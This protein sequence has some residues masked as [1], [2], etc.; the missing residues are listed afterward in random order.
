MQLQFDALTIAN[1]EELHETLLAYSLS[2]ESLLELD[3]HNVNK[4][5]LSAIQLFL[6]LQKTLH[7]EKRQLKLT[8]CTNGVMAALALCGCEKILAGDCQ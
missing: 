7:N 3:L 6:S 8:N 1:I 5:D 2:Q 4:I